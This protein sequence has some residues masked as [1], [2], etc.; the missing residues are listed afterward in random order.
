MELE[1][2]LISEER[3]DYKC[4]DLLRELLKNEE[5][6]KV[7]RKG[8]EG[9]KITGFSEDV[10]TKIYNQNTGVVE[11]Y[12]DEDFKVGRNIGDCSMFSQRLSYSFD[13]TI[14]GGTLSWLKGTRNSPDGRHMWMVS[15]GFIYDTSLMLIID[16][17]FSKELGYDQLTKYDISKFP[18]Y[19]SSWEQFIGNDHQSRP[20]K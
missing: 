10:W 11:N 2:I 7:V 19:D 9:G 20:R 14:C 17:R 3:K 1:K 8:I 6:V 18:Y 5:F 13:K 16:E 4:F 15:Q 12:F